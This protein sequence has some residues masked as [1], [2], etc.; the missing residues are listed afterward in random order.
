MRTRT[1]ISIN[2][3]TPKT[4]VVPETLEYIFCVIPDTIDEKIKS[5]TPLE[6]P[7]SVINSP[8]HISQIDPTVITNADNK[9][10]GKVVG[11]TLPPRR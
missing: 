10:L 1:M 8:N 5:D 6:T 4:F 9:M 7:C 11:M 3:I 2:A